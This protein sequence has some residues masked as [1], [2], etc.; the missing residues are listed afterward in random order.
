MAAWLLA[1]SLRTPSHARKKQLRI[2]DCFLGLIAFMNIH[3][4]FCLND[5]INS[6]NRYVI[7]K[8]L[9][10]LEHLPFEVNLTRTSGDKCYLCRSCFR[11]L[12][13]RENLIRSP[14]R[15]K[16]GFE[17]R[18]KKRKLSTSCSFESAI[19][20]D[21][22]LRPSIEVNHPSSKATTTIT[23]SK[24]RAPVT[25]F[26]ARTYF[27]SCLRN[28]QINRTKT[29]WSSEGKQSCMSTITY[30]RI[31]YISG[32]MLSKNTR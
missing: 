6:T 9:K 7:D 13:K 3:S 17:T 25:E 2:G 10:L 26:V 15:K 24:T 30:M 20:R 27:D 23:P 8:S 18:S 29:L 4:V 12:K 14:V 19:E 5:I 31:L 32:Q 16:L 11:E 21:G 1:V 28:T 22:Q